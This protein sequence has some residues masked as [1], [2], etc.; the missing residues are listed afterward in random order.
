MMTGSSSP[1]GRAARALARRSG[2]T[3]SNDSCV[4]PLLSCAARPPG[5]TTNTKAASA[6]A[7]VFVI[8]ALLF[9]GVILSPC[10]DEVFNDGAPEHTPRSRPHL[11]SPR[12]TGE[13]GEKVGEMRETGGRGLLSV[14]GRRSD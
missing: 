12:S 4:P 8:N 6:S 1:S 7:S 13:H 3:L 11:C 5:A 2:E 10:P 9:E 14:R